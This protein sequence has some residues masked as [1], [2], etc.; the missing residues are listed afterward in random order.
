MS[1]GHGKLQRAILDS[2]PDRPVCTFE[3]A[4]LAHH[5]DTDPAGV[6]AITASQRAATARALY[7][8]E[9]Q[10]LVAKPVSYTHLTLPTTPYV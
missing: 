8:L 4:G 2:L 7:S 3:V 5:V 1:K 10:G 6:V 9:G